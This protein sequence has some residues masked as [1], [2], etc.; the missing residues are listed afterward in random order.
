MTRHPQLPRG[1]AMPTPNVE[2]PQEKVNNSQRH[3]AA[4]QRW[5]PLMPILTALFAEGLSDALIGERIGLSKSTVTAQRHRCGMKRP[6]RPGTWTQARQDEL[7]R[8]FDEGLSAA[9]IGRR[10]SLT[11]NTVIGR[12]D[13]NGM[14][15]R[16][17]FTP[18]QPQRNYF[19]GAYSCLWGYGDVGEDD[20]H[21]CG[22]PVTAIGE[23]W[24]SKHR[25]IVFRRPEEA[26]TFEDQD[27]ES[28]IWHVA[29]Y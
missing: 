3:A 19:N 13:R 18:H 24:C 17:T 29:R 14:T 5:A 4:Q 10:M 23:S 20:F 22:A 1:E 21:F 6:P 8:L 16:H 11:K 26:L 28:I 2:A 15:R 12:L 25:A 27:D 7:Q 9:E